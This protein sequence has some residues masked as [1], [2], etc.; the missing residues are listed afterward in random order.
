MGR[1]EFIIAVKYLQNQQS[2]I[3]RGSYACCRSLG[4]SRNT[5]AEGRENPYSEPS[6]TDYDK[7]RRARPGNRSIVDT[8]SRSCGASVESWWC[9]MSH[10]VPPSYLHILLLIRVSGHQRQNSA[11][12]ANLPAIQSPAASGKIADFLSQS[13][14]R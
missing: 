10:F 7:G 1:P 2:S 9:V 13:P 12:G 3:S 11:S 6:S 4:A 5:V 14:Q 8:C